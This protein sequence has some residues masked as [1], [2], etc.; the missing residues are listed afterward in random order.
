M[1]P[2]TEALIGVGALVALL[3]LSALLGGRGNPLGEEDPRPSTLLAGP[4]G[5][6]GLADGLARLGIE[7]RRFRHPISQLEANDGAGPRTA[8]AVLDPLL[9][10]R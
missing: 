4:F 10:T 6:R 9:E 7:V 1:Q 8:L 3:S 2:R 5:A